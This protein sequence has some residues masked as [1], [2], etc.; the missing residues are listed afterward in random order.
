MTELV[1]NTGEF[2]DESDSDSVHDV[3][4]NRLDLRH[5]NNGKSYIYDAEEF[6]QALPLFK[7][8]P[9]VFAKLHPQNIG[10]LPLE[11]ALKE[12]DGRLVGTPQDV[13]VNNSGTLF[14]GKLSI[15]DEEVNELIRTGKARLSTAFFATPDENGV[16][17]NIIPN[18]ILVYP[19]ST[20]IDPG[21]HAALFLNQNELFEKVGEPMVDE[22][23]PDTYDLVRELVQ[24]QAVKD[25]LQEKL[26]EQ[27]EVI[28][29][30]KTE[31]D[32]KD[33][34]ISEKD[35]LIAEKDK[36]IT[37]QASEI[38]TLTAKVAELSASIADNKLSQKKARR[39]RVFNQFLPGTR[40]A[41]EERKEEIYDDERF[42]EI[43]I[44]MFQHQASVGQPP[45]DESGSEDV[46]NQGKTP[47]DVIDAEAQ[48]AWETSSVRL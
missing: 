44:E 13:L 2:V 4:L 22:V 6:R 43:F 7:E 42:E 48:K 41:F 19:S 21:D 28:F 5:S 12:V 40:K 45:V 30:Q 15:S 29:N 14:R 8:T 3:I 33:R 9:L 11:D 18:H 35:S 26:S 47:D 17:R 27:K 31:L 23:K 20:G 25:E 38:E 16:L 24:N 37:N 36:L 34:V 46:Q 10:K 1:T 39:D 32:N